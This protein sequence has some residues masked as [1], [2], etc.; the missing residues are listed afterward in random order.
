MTKQGIG[1][2]QGIYTNVVKMGKEYAVGR[3][4]G[5]VGAS[6]METG[7]NQQRDLIEAIAQFERF[8]LPTHEEIFDDEAR[9]AL[10]KEGTERTWSN[11]TQR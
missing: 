9:A 8:K 3:L 11:G 4:A 5:N 1:Y 7:C 6:M 10:G 2:L